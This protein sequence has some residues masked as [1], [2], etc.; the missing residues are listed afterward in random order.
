MDFNKL[1]EKMSRKITHKQL[2]VIM[3]ILL[4]GIAALV[5]V[6][7][8][9][10][11]PIIAL[12]NKLFSSRSD[13]APSTDSI[14][15][16][17]PM[18]IIDPGHGGS[19]PG[20]GKGKIIEKDITLAISLEIEKV[21]REKSISYYMLRTDDTFVSLEDRTSI[22]NEKQGRLFISI[23]I[24]SFTD[25]SANGVLTTYNPYSLNGKEYAEIM[26]SKLINLGMKNR[27][28]MSRPDLYVLRHTEMPSLLLEIGF[29]SN[30]KDYKLLTD[31][32][33]QQKCASQVVNGIEEI[34]HKINP[35][36]AESSEAN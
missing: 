8:G 13:S 3:I 18:V 19:E 32:I 30:S 6:K 21:L 26:Q 29:I 25:S 22:A 16:D 20:A 24:N 27:K 14:K 31:T 12:T 4:V 15:T 11:N 17:A 36:A 28:T 5:F 1:F 10:D 2:I 33:F 9:G 7:L 34:L 23:H 35:D